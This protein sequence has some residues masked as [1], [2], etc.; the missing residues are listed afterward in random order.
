MKND[1]FYITTPIY[2]P[3][4][5]PH[6]GHAY[7]TLLCDALARFHS[8]NGKEVYF[9]TGTDENTQKV[10]QAAEKAGV[11]PHQFLENVV[12][13]FKEVYALLDINYSQ[14]I[15]TSDQEVHWPGVVEIWNRLIENGDLYKGKYEGLYCTGC[16][17]FLKEKDLEDGKCPSH[18]IEP[19]R[20][21]E[22]NYFFKL[23]KY[24]TDIK[25]LI[26]NDRIQI[27]PHS[28]K[29]EVLAFLSGGLEDVSFTRPSK[30]VEWGV[31]VPGDETQRMYVWMDALTNYITALGFGRGEENM[32]FWP[33]THVVG[34]D[35]L[36]F[37]AIIWPAMLIAAKL[38]QPKAILVHGM[39][40]S[41]GRKMSK[42][43]GNVIKPDDLIDEYGTDAVRYLLLREINPFEDS[44]ITPE[45]L[46]E[47]YNA[48]LANGLG[49]LSSRIMK[50]AE[51]HL[52]EPV[53]RPKERDFPSEYADAVKGYRI[54]RAMDYIW[55][56]I[57]KMDEKITETEPFKLVKTD[58]AA[59]QK[60][61]CELA[62]ELYTVAR[63]L[64]PFMPET[65]AKIK[66]AVLAN[67]KPEA[68]FLRKE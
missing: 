22:E 68:L 25:E 8:G 10:I 7:S 50:L 13:R 57:G 47:A 46:K 24:T 17:A 4:A 35:I 33:G 31:P 1:K 12:S 48:N 19:Q 42:S 38:P 5:E 28:R 14:F 59:A 55:Q 66:A 11:D 61:I 60:I 21:S 37:H 20:L 30:E 43:L 56:R 53:E 36:R 27:T 45:R 34:K 41:G 54:D 26:E 49:N 2:Y 40:I 52:E 62:E 16:E 51:T 63:M 39:I 9:L 6:L 32:A 58:K 67:K 64:T 18:G 44:D 23:S 29:A 65:S 15:R 3:N